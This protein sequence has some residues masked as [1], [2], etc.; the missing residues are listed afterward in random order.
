MSAYCRRRR[1]IECV[2]TLVSEQIRQGLTLLT[3][4]LLLNRFGST[5]TA[6][7]KRMSLSIPTHVANQAVKKC[8]PLE[9]GCFM[10]HTGVGVCQQRVDTK[11]DSMGVRR[12]LTAS[13]SAA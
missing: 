9:A 4:G 3:N 5:V 11:V 10:W 1:Q 6:R 8:G 2:T 13:N 7:R 12:W